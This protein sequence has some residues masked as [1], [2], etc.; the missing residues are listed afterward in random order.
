MD[1]WQFIVVVLVAVGFFGVIAWLR[2]GSD[3]RMPP[4]GEPGDADRADNGWW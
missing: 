2:T 1:W 3:G 4:P